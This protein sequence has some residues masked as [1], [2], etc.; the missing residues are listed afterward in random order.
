MLTPHPLPKTPVQ[1]SLRA[2]LGLPAPLP[3][4]GEESASWP[5]PSPQPQPTTVDP[6]AWIAWCMVGLPLFDGTRLPPLRLALSQARRM[7]LALAMLRGRGTITRAAASLQLSRKVLRDNLRALGL[8]PWPEQATQPPA[9]T[10]GPQR[11]DA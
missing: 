4:P 8:Y 10:P 9:R 7:L 1:Q 3:L 11:P 2:L 6:G 5:Q